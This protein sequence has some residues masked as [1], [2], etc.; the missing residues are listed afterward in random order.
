MRYPRNQRRS[1]TNTRQ[2]T[3]THHQRCEQHQQGPDVRRCRGRLGVIAAAVLLTKNNRI[4]CTQLVFDNSSTHLHV[5]FH[6]N[7]SNTYWSFDAPPG[8]TVA[9]GLWV[10]RFGVYLAHYIGACRVTEEYTLTTST[11]QQQRQQ[12]TQVDDSYEYP[13]AR[14]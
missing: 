12:R 6:C 11:Q 4:V 7:Y 13:A 8:V 10:T 5:C 2:Q 9:T 3:P 1:Q 14:S